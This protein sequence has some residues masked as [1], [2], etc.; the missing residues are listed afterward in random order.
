ML[1]M[2]NAR[3]KWTF[4][5]NHAHV[6][7]ALK[8]DPDARVRDLADAVTIT[9]R[10]VQ[11][12]LTDL[13]EAGIIAREREGRRNRYSVNPNAPLRHP[14]ESGGTVRDLLALVDTGPAL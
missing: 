4:L 12:I 14:N 3:R 1:K 11:Q 10:A 2:P 8:R 5:T 9:E 13:E 6:L 7:I